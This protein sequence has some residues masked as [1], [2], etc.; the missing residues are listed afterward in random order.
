MDKIVSE[1][2]S[3]IKEKVRQLLYDTYSQDKHNVNDFI[4]R[5]KRMF[6][7][8]YIE[9]HYS[10]NQAYYQITNIS[11]YIKNGYG[12]GIELSS[13]DGDRYG[14]NVSHRGID[15]TIFSRLAK[16]N[17][18]RE[19][20]TIFFEDEYLEN[21][22]LENIDKLFDID[23]SV[24]SL[25]RNEDNNVY[26]FLP[27]KVKDSEDVVTARYK[28]LKEEAEYQNKDEVEYE[29]ISPYRRFGCNNSFNRGFTI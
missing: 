23:L 18:Y 9:E 25:T 12:I 17:E 26:I 10:V 15:I 11:Y 19:G 3:S 24:K 20:I 16:D 4:G 6:K 7:E 8:E 29:A 14:N 2:L 13:G 27:E 5:F 1:E 22:L 28:Q 21:Q